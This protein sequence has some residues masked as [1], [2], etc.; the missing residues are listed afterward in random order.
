MP[1][2]PLHVQDHGLTERLATLAELDDNDRDNLLNVLDALIT[3]KRLRALASDAN[4]S[5]P[6]RPPDPGQPQPEGSESIRA[7]NSSR[8][9]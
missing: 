3:R 7:P 5:Q 2:R 9:R 4:C 1:R 8:S 6:Q